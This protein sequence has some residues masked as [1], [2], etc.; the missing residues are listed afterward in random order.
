MLTEIEY[1]L[2]T[3][4]LDGVLLNSNTHGQYLGMPFFEPVLAELNRRQIPVFLHP[5]HG[6]HITELSLAGRARSL[7]TPSTPRATSPTRSTGASSSATR[8]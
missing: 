4:H 1:A 6:P 3:L 2:D 5:T 7:S 8:T